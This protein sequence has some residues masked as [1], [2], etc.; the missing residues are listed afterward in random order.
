MSGDSFDVTLGDDAIDGGGASPQLDQQS[1]SSP[2]SQQ[3]T[4]APPSVLGAFIRERG[5][6]V[7]DDATDDDLFGH[8]QTWAKRA[9][10]IP[11]DVDPEEL[12]RTHSEYSKYRDEFQQFLSTRSQQAA[13][14]QP[15]QSLSPQPQPQSLAQPQSQQQQSPTL[16]SS[17]IE[18]YKQVC[19]WDAENGVYKPK[20]PGFEA[21]AAK[22]NEL[23]YQR[24]Q[25]LERLSEDPDEFI[26]TRAERIAEERA[27][28]LLE[29]RL[30]E[31][32]PDI[33]SWREYKS[34]IEQD[35]LI[36]P[37]RQELV[38][39]TESGEF[40]SPKGEVFSRAFDSAPETLTLSQK[41]TWAKN[42][43]DLWAA[44]TVDA[45]PAAAKPNG[46]TLKPIG[47]QQANAQQQPTQR[48][49]QPQAQQQPP[50]D[51]KKKFVDSGR[52]VARDPSTGQFVPDRSGLLNAAMNNGHATS[53]DR[54]FVQ[55]YQ[56]LKNSGLDN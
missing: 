25:N 56:D 54:S 9:T 11:E 40:L 10:A 55:V 12:V 36:A 21:Q 39:Q 8:I 51:Q 4:S 46:W 1:A 22:L 2:D 26:K 19:V 6:D 37:F 27:N 16:D 48:T 53:R 28:A 47:Q 42:Q 33:Q 43:A 5:F 44:R 38:Q 34:Q 15:S 31:L 7:P 30:A 41:V 24:R 13:N 23:A 17:A 20:V 50:V 14:P 49:Q 32:M 18:M 52:H 35:R 45:T 29:K 3:Q